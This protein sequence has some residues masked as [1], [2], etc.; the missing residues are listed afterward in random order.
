MTQVSKTKTVDS[1][2]VKIMDLL[3]YMNK[4]KELGATVKFR[5]I[6]LSLYE[7]EVDNLEKIINNKNKQN[8]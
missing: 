4:A 8:D 3:N 2:I 1:Q 7:T 6:L 5:N